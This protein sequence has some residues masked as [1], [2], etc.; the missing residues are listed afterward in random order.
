[1]PSGQIEP[2]IAKMPLEAQRTPAK[3]YAAELKATGRSQTTVASYIGVLGILSRAYPTKPFTE[4][5]KDDLIEFL[6]RYKG[7]S[8]NSMG[9]TI[10]AFLKWCN[11]TDV[12]PP[13]IG[14]WKPR[15]PKGFS[16]NLNQLLSED[17]IRKMV[18]ETRGLQEKCLIHTLFDSGCR[19]GEL[20]ALKRVGVMFDKVGAVIVIDGKTGP[21]RIRLV[22]SAPILK[23]WLNASPSLPES[24]VFPI[25]GT[26]AWRIVHNAGKKILGREIHAHLL[27]HSKATSLTLRNVSE[28][29]LRQQFGWTRNSGMTARYVHM[30]GKD[31]DREILKANGISVPDEPRENI[32]LKPVNCPLCAKPNDAT[33]S[34]CSQCGGSLLKDVKTLAD[35]LTERSERSLRAYANTIIQLTAKKSPEEQANLTPE[36][37]MEDIPEVVKQ[38]AV[39]LQRERKDW[40]EKQAKAAPGNE[41]RQ[42]ELNREYRDSLLR[43]SEELEQKLLKAME[44]RRILAIEAGKKSVKSGLANPNE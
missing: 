15:T 1:M 5:T 44:A 37:L 2:K 3:K 28:P 4:L 27:R 30:S 26:T 22:S 21:R 32:A 10:K 13:S 17:D 36:Q 39:A 23:E 35:E 33:M 24:R 11:G 14:W 16:I 7:N 9:I 38:V 40:E 41:A 31:V 8:Q 43:D 42:A 29:A 25:S 6:G 19:I 20:L 12:P 34:Y 18:A